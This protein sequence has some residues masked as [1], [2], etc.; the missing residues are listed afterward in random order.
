MSPAVF[1]LLLVFPL[2]ACSGR[3]DATPL[4]TKQTAIDPLMKKLDAAA[5][6]EQKRREEM[7]EAAK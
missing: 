7:D 3:P 1:A 6:Q 2:V 5:Q 4:P